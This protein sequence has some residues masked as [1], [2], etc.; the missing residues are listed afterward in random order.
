MNDRETIGRRGFWV[1]ALLWL[2]AGVVA[3]AAVRFGARM[4]AS[5]D[6][7]MWPALLAAAGSL[8][9]VAPCGLPLALGCRRLW[10]LRYR[11][12]AWVAGIGLGT[13]YRC[14]IGGGR[15]CSG[16]VAIAVYAIVFSLPVHGAPGG[17]WCGAADCWT[18]GGPAAQQ[19]GRSSRL[20]AGSQRDAEFGYPQYAASGASLILESPDGT[21][22]SDLRIEGF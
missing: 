11:R 18:D 3:Q 7:H 12:G 4:G 6:P 8:V 16:P 21:C 14:R 20:Y 5:G 22:R 9:L 15:A 2:P 19:A 17:G 1:L 10:R 13:A